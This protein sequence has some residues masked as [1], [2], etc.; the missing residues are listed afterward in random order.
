MVRRLAVVADEHALQVYEPSA[1]VVVTVA[2]TDL[3]DG[4][5]VL[6]GWTTPWAVVVPA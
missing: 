2:R 3:V 5:L 6:A 4:G 1:G